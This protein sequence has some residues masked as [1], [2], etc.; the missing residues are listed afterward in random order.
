MAAI[1]SYF[2]LINKRY[3]SGSRPLING[4]SH[5]C[6][7]S[8]QISQSKTLGRNPLETS[9][10]QHDPQDDFFTDQ[11]TQHP[12]SDPQSFVK[13][14]LKPGEAMGLKTEEL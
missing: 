14:D 7:S 11:P 4:G 2:R 6:F 10:N 9:I 12:N 5:F 13:R 1:L 3:I 8:N